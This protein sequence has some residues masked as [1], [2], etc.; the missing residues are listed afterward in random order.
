MQNIKP[1]IHIDTLNRTLRNTFKALMDMMI[2]KYTIYGDCMLFYLMTIPDK[3]Q[4]IANYIQSVLGHSDNTTSV[5]YNTIKI[6]S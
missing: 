4:T 1:K 5:Y 6:E 3:K 2:L